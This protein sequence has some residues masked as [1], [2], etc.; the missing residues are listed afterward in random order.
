MLFA[1]SLFV[2]HGGFDVDLDTL[3]DWNLWLRYLGAAGGFAFVD[4]TTSRYRVPLDRTLFD[5]RRATLDADYAAAQAKAKAI[6]FHA[7]VGNL[8]PEVDEVRRVEAALRPQ[9]QLGWLLRTSAWLVAHRSYHGVR[10]AVRELLFP[11]RPPSE[12]DGISS[13]SM[14][15]FE[16]TARTACK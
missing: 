5:A 8:A 6:A 1:R 3:E 10:V 7:T 4:K 14:R 2:E 9:P 13:R 11:K 12:S 15:W 16:A